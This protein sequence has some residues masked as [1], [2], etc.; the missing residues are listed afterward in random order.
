MVEALRSP[1]STTRATRSDTPRYVRT[2][3]RK[4]KNPKETGYTKNARSDERN[5]GGVHH[6]NVSVA[7]HVERILESSS[8][9]PSSRAVG[10]S[11]LASSRGRPR[12]VLSHHC[13]V[14]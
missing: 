8:R 9:P 1:Y 4:R 13:R 5:R 2:G 12:Y 14:G 6:G 3:I 11:L 7:L 10:L